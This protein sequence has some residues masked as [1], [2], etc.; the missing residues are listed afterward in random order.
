MAWDGCISPVDTPGKELSSIRTAQTLAVRL[1]GG[2][3]YGPGSGRG[4]PAGNG[5]LLTLCPPTSSRCPWPCCFCCPKSGCWPAAPRG[6]PCSCLPTSWRW[7]RSLLRRKMPLPC[8]PSFSHTQVGALMTFATHSP[9]PRLP[10]CPLPPEDERRSHPGGWKQATALLAWREG[11]G[12]ILP[13]R[14][15]S[16]CHPTAPASPLPRPTCVTWAEL[17]DRSEACLHQD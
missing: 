8:P 10:W 1:C 5:A 4:P 3:C 16:G 7:R 6:D 13:K 9:T 12:A 14:A 2:V 11:A 15:G 17:L